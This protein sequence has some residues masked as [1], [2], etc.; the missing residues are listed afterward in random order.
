MRTWNEFK[1]TVR[2]DTEVF[3][4]TR[5]G[6][7]FAMA[8]FLARNQHAVVERDHK[9]H[10]ALMLAAYLG[11]EMT[12][13]VLIAAGADPNDTDDGGGTILMG[14]AFKGHLQVVEALVEAGGRVDAVNAKGQSALAFAQ[15]FG[16]VEVA[17]YLKS[18][19]R[20]PPV[21]GM[22]DV[23]S[24]WGSFIFGRRRST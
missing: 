9:G 14:A 10:S 3:L 15:M 20:K 12:A 6:D 19:Q 4:L 1:R 17:K 18:M 8:D 22:G 7:P 23:L 24:G 21:F 11:H 13:R 2:E 5:G 16:R